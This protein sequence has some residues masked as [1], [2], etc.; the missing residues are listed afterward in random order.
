M[1]TELQK[2]MVGGTCRR[3]C[4]SWQLLLDIEKNAHVLGG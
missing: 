4:C 2:C 1:N 3:G